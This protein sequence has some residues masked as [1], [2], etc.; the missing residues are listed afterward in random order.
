MLPSFSYARPKNLSDALRQL[1]APGARV[2]AGGTDLLGCLRDGVFGAEA[3]ASLARLA[4]QGGYQLEPL[5]AA[6]AAEEETD[7]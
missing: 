6:Q 4:A 2:Q 3:A 5:T 1:A 7:G